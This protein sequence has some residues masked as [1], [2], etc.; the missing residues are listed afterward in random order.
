[1]KWSSFKYLVKQGWHN[2]VANRLMT[3]ASMGVLVACLFIT[4]VA[5]LLSINVNSFVDYLSAQ[6]EVEV[7]LQKDAAEEAIATLKTQVEA[8]PNVSE[9]AYISRAQAVEEM[10]GWMGENSDLLTAYEGEGNPQNPLI[11]SLRVK[12]AE[13]PQLAQT[14]ADIQAAGGETIMRIES[15]SDLSGVLVGLKRVVTYVGWGLVGILGVVSVVVISNTIRLTVFARRKEINI[16][17]FVGATNAFIRLPFFVEGITVGALSGLFATGVVCGCYY[18]VLR[19]L[20]QPSIKWLSE[21]TRC[22][23]PLT[24]VW[25]PLLIGFVVFGAILG[26]VGCATSI[27]KHLKV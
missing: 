19:A 12:I 10:K 2:M 20:A 17:K 13:L 11:A 27:R 8:M 16:M 6:N 26:G 22:V 1:M 25:A 18:G 23:Y 3:L 21:F 14:V 5:M 24:S 7:Y 15:P 9:C 4:G